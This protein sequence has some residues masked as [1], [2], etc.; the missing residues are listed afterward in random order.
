[1]VELILLFKKNLTKRQYG[2]TDGIFLE[3]LD[4]KT[5]QFNPYWLFRNF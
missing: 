4:Q 5:L 3:N 1:M 2:L